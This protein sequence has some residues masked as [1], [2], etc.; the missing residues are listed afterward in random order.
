MEYGLETTIRPTRDWQLNSRSLSF[1]DFETRLVNRTNGNPPSAVVTL[2][3]TAHQGLDAS[4]SKIVQYPVF[5][6]VAVDQCGLADLLKRGIAT[7]HNTHQTC[8]DARQ[9][10]E[11]LNEASH[12]AYLC[13]HGRG[14]LGKVTSWEKIDAGTM[15][16]FYAGPAANAKL[17][18][19]QKPDVNL[20]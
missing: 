14:E 5:A 8:D 1:R 17:A 13:K 6:Y 3:V 2:P 20:V 9:Q 12:S 19:T 16:G 10:A 15:Q 11:S 4:G 7:T 18:R